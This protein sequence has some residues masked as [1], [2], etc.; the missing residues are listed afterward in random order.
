[1]Q[2]IK[3]KIM[4]KMLTMYYKA[5]AGHIGS[6]LSCLDILIDIYFNK[7]QDG[8]IFILSKGHAAGALYC[9]LNAKGVISD[10]LLDTFYKDGT[11]M[12]AHPNASIPGVLFATGSLGHGLSLAVGIAMANKKINVYCLLGD[13]DCQEG[14]T[15]EALQFILQHRPE[16]LFV[17]LDLN[18]LQ[19]L[20][21]VEDILT[22]VP[23]HNMLNYKPEP[24]VKGHGISF[25]ENKYEWHYWPMNK[26]QY[27]MAMKGVENA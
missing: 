26:E 25:M 6:A 5:N 7:M 2:E 21:R 27:E 23:F 19:G 16:N 11:V 15:Y 9:V 14:Q 3:R 13:G 12:A 4:K 18:G 8:D 1:M 17:K 22:A 10:E 24:T 20:G